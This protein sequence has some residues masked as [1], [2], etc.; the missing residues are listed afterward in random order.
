MVPLVLRAA[1]LLQVD[2]LEVFRLA[3]RYW[4]HRCD[5]PSYIGKAFHK[6]LHDKISPPWVTHFA[7]RVVQAYNRGNFDP[8]SFGVYPEF[9]KLP[10]TWSLALQT[11][12]YVRLR[13]NCHVLVA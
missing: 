1:N 4:N 5:E 7:R 13:K 8:V 2:E 10:W 12:R 6:Y 11:P 9:D 3:H